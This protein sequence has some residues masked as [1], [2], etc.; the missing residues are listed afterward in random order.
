MQLTITDYQIQC[1]II[2]P[3]MIKNR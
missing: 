2:A 1:L 3:D